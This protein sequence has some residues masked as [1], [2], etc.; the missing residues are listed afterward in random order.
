[1]LWGPDWPAQ[2]EVR[3]TSGQSCSTAAALCRMP[4]LAVASPAV[5]SQWC[6]H[7]WCCSSSCIFVLLLCMRMHIYSAQFTTDSKPP[8]SCSSCEKRD[9]A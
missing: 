5:A 9:S 8:D 7:Q 2:A 1:M 4:S 3:L 6:A